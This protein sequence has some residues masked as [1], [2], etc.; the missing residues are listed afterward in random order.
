MLGVEPCIYLLPR[1][2]C[3]E[4]STLV[5]ARFRN[6]IHLFNSNASL[7]VTLLQ[8]KLLKVSLV[9]DVAVSTPAQT[10]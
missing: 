10:A 6:F 2:V 3:K 5:D 1:V 8:P 7:D 4:V 9:F